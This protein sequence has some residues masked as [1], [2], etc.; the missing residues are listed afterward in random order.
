MSMIEFICCLYQVGGYDQ[1]GNIEDGYQYIWKTQ[2]KPALAGK[3]LSPIIHCPFK[4]IIAYGNVDI[5]R[6]TK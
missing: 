4:C 5:L 3:V 6:L 2:D 1:V